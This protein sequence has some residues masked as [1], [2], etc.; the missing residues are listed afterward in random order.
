MLPR[1]SASY[2]GA[3]VASTL[4]AGFLGAGLALLFPILQPHALVFVV[5]GASVHVI[6]MT[7]THRFE[8]ADARP[9]VWERILFWGCWLILAAVAAWIVWRIR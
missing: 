4:G 6:G 2:K 8:A 3:Q 7:L 9:S 1:R 5:V